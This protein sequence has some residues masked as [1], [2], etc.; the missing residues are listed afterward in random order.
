MESGPF[1]G[2]SLHFIGI[3]GAGMSG[4]ALVADSLGAAVSGSDR[5]ESSYW[6]PLTAA[7]IA[8]A[9][10]H[11]AANVPDGAEVV[12]STAIPEDN[13]EL[14]AAHAAGA[15][16]LHRGDLLGEL[17]RMKRTIAVGGTHGKTTTASMAALALLECGREPAFLIGG[18]LRAAGTNAAWGEGEWAVIE[19]DES[20]RSFLKLARE[21]AVVTSVE[22]DHHATYATVGALEQAFEEFAE[23]AALR[24]LGPELDRF[25]DGRASVSY[26]IAAGD[27]Q[28]RDLELHPGGARFSVEDVEVELHVPGRHN[29]LNA[30]AAL[31]SC[32]AAG[33]ELA[34]AGPALAA[35][36][37]A[38]RRF[39]EHGRTSTG[40]LVY[41][42]YA[43]HP[44]EVRATLEAAR[45][46]QP[47]R[48]LA[49]FQPHLYSRTRMLA[50]E[51]GRALALADVV[52]VLDVYPARERAED[53]PG[54]SGLLVAEAA[55]DAA[56]G[57]PVWWLPRTSD[58]ARMLRS[59]LREGDLLLT[60]GAGDVDA[61]AKELVE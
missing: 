52:V 60:I 61:L 24:V 49:C 12:V 37:G 33:L 11:D 41:D 15:P 19:A 55:A 10:G 44:T 20:D 22:L 5:A 46:L 2:R 17:S 23:P 38:G 26:G 32:R 51:F 48:L 34:D 35:F 16:V 58:A 57:R 39:E 14:V 4:L 1:E 27:L 13:P 18:E 47:A 54:V 3:G 45:T 40:A 7:G 43:H 31:A 50:R 9:R 29:V 59:E 42:D 30:L 56:H 21:I 53:F 8:P 25:G 28:A 36:T 6:G